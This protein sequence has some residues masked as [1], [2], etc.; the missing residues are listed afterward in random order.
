MATHPSYTMNSFHPIFFF[1]KF[2]SHKQM[3]Y[4]EKLIYVSN[5]RLVIYT[6]M[7]LM[8]NKY[9]YNTIQYNNQIPTLITND[10]QAERFFFSLLTYLSM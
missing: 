10:L 2:D 5:Y 4:A 7:F 1:S 3:H 6:C 9:L 8:T